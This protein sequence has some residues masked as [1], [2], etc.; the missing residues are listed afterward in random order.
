MNTYYI[1]ITCRGDGRYQERVRA[2]NLINAMKQV[3]KR[4]KKENIVRSLDEV[5]EN[6]FT[7]ISSDWGID[8]SA[9]D[10]WNMV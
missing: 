10:K 4:F 1:T 7:D 3:Q 6:C 8:I 2:K 9:K 5:F